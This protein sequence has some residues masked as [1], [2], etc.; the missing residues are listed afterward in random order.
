[1]A[2]VTPSE[3]TPNIQE[4]HIAMGHAFCLL[5]ERAMFADG[6]RNG[7]AARRSARRPKRRTS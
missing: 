7:T 3:I 5:V 4:G 1:V 6:A 2:L